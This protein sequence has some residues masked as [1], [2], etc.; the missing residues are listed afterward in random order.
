MELNAGALA[1]PEKSALGL[2]LGR[3]PTYHPK[4]PDGQL[5][6]RVHL[7]AY[8]AHQ[9]LGGLPAGRERHV[10]LLTTQRSKFAPHQETLPLQRELTQR[11]IGE[12]T[13][14]YRPRIGGAHE[15]LVADQMGIGRRLAQS[16]AEQRG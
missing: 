3:G 8:E 16:P 4:E 15:E 7:P 2:G 5:A 14:F 6:V 12:R 11:E 13:I 9:N 10:D 1:T